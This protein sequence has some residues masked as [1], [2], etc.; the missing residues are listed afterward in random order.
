MIDPDHATDPIPEP[1]VAMPISKPDPAPAPESLTALAAGSRGKRLYFNGSA[2]TLDGQGVLILGR[3]GA[4]KSRLALG[5]LA[6]GA[7][8]IADD[9]VFL[10]PASGS[11]HRP[12]QSPALIEARG[13]GLLRAPI[14]V[15]TAPLGWVVDLDRPETARLPP[16]RIVATA[17]VSCPLILGADHPSLATALAHLIRH[18]RLDP[19]AD[20]PDRKPDP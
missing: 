11:L 20:R 12:A 17:A 7:G 18:G 6:A 9:G 19:D 14:V 2:V 8:L 4:G 16:R 13:I 3:P 10:D 5:L 15:E 1:G